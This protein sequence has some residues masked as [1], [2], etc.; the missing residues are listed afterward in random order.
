MPINP[1]TKFGGCAQLCASAVMAYSHLQP[2]GRNA[3]AS[4]SKTVIF[5]ALIGNMLISITKFVAASIT[6]S[7]AMLSEGIHSLVDFRSTKESGICNI[8]NRLPTPMLSTLCWGWLCCSKVP[9]GTSLSVNSA[10]SR[11]DGVISR[12]FS[13]PRIR[14]YLWC[15]LRTVRPCWDWWWHLSAYC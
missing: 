8:P 15:C 4:G 10:G 1:A 5:A 13:A 3:M 6:G 9:P 14:Q 2:S 7:S 11:D 12:Q